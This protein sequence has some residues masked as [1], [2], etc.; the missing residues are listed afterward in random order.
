MTTSYDS[1]SLILHSISTM[2]H[3]ARID[4]ISADTFFPL[5]GLEENHLNTFSHYH[6][7]QDRYI[8]APSS[9]HKERQFLQ[10]RAISLKGPE[11]GLPDIPLPRYHRL[12][13]KVCT[14]RKSYDFEILKLTYLLLTW[15][16]FHSSHS[17]FV[18]MPPEI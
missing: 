11:K 10:T 18:N 17:Q 8:R 9:R 13:L 2:T 3:K 4:L 15:R 5:M 7:T 14:F 16:F 1:A 6:L 12:K